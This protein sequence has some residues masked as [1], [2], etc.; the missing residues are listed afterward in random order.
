MGQAGR[1]ATTGAR[2]LSLLSL[3][4]AR[5]DWPGPELAERLGVSSRTLRRDVERLRELGYPVSAVRGL[6][7]GYQL[8]AG[9]SMPPLA[10]QDEEAVA[11]VVGLQASVGAAPALAEPALR[12]LAKAVRV[13]PPR[14]RR[15]VEALSA[16]TVLGAPGAGAPGLDP[17][18][19]LVV[20]QAAQDGERVALDYTAADG[21]ASARTVEPHHLVPLRRSWYL[22]AHDVDRAD[23][24]VFRLDR[25]S[26]ARGTGARFRH[27]DPPADDVAAWLRR[28]VDAAPF[29]HEV[30]AVLHCP[31]ERAR[32][33]VGAWA[34]V[35]ELAD[36]R[37]RVAFSADAL[38]WAAFALGRVG[39]EISEVEPPELVAEL[40]GWAG[41]FRRAAA[42]APRSRRTAP[43]RAAG[44]S[45]S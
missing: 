24:R 33:R 39:C 22:L 10:L 11:L 42:G 14:L 44:A 3:L 19:L 28:R 31:A 9:A 41:R 26:S 18:V 1:V 45:R 20:A 15:Q 38:D 32:E 35:E 30:S 5:R 29:G 23:W 6:H 2:T 4:Q 27:R 17:A 36:D 37:C 25:I 43:A 16:R 21:R 34:R 13:L 40:R 12:A 7:G 8:A